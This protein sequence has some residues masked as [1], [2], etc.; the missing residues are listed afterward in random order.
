MAKPNKKERHDKPFSVY[1][2]A[3]I[4]SITL[5]LFALAVKYIAPT[6]WEASLNA[7]WWKWVETFTGWHVM[8]AIAEHF[9]H[10]YMLHA[11]LKLADY[12][13]FLAPL[14]RMNVQHEYHHKITLV[15]L[16]TVKNGHGKVFN[17]YPIVEV[18]QHD[19]SY[20][21]WYS[22]AGFL[23]VSMLGVIP[24]Q[25]L[26]P[27]WPI[28]LGAASAITFSITLYELIHAI[29][30]FSFD[31]FWKPKLFHPRW[32]KLWTWFYCIHLVHHLDKRDKVNQNISGCFGFALADWLFNT[33]VSWPRVYEHGEWV[34]AA[35]FNVPIPKPC[36]LIRWLDARL[37]PV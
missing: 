21:P 18:H 11:P 26:L 19:A 32:G 6:V 4:I 30:H 13:P 9:F 27:S 1:R 15:K 33:Y 35:E 10:R 25:I 37:L 16:V 24:L 7:P 22:L 14:K 29:E 20:F 34:P 28:L 36:W 3:I 2:F 8:C 23:A 5:A 31:T 17:R 12:L